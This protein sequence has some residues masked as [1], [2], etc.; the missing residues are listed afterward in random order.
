MLTYGHRCGA[1]MAYAKGD[2]WDCSAILLDTADVRVKH[3]ARL[4]FVFY[5]VKS[6]HQPSAGGVTDGRLT[7]NGN[8]KHPMGVV[9]GRGHAPAFRAA[10]PAKVP[11]GQRP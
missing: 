7:P 10:V 1:G 2:G 5:E 11:V 4:P 9:V 6:E 8:G 3:E